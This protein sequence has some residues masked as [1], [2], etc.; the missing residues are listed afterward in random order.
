MFVDPGPDRSD[1]IWVALRADLFAPPDR[2]DWTRRVTD[3]RIL[4]SDRSR[5]YVS[6]GVLLL[7]IAASLAVL[8][9]VLWWAWLLL[10]VGVAQ[11]VL[12]I[13]L[14]PR[15]RGAAMGDSGNDLLA[16]SVR[17]AN[18][19]YERLPFNL[20]GLLGAVAVPVNVLIAIFLTGPDNPGPAKVGLFV[21]TLLYAN[22][23]I[24]GTLMDTPWFSPRSLIDARVHRAQP[25]FWLLV[26]TAAVA[27]VLG[28]AM[29]ERWPDGSLPYALLACGLCYHIG[30]RVRDYCRTM[31]AAARVL[32]Q[33]S[34]E[35]RVS[36]A[37]MLHDTLQPAKYGLP[38]VIESADLSGGQRAALRTMVSDIEELYVE[39]Q[40][41][42]VDSGTLLRASFEQRVRQLVGSAGV[43]YRGSRFDL[44]G[45]LDADNHRF[46][47]H[48][49]TNL[50]QNARDAY[51]SDPFL[52]DHPAIVVTMWLDD[53][54]ASIAVS[55]NLAPIPEIVFA[56]PGS[57]LGSL[58]DR[59]RVQKGDLTQAV[60]SS[61]KTITARWSTALR[62]LRELTSEE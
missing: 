40:R 56:R 47:H 14:E 62:P 4:T 20:T 61:G 13:L 36:L 3:E 22:S 18:R 57:T 34:V 25:F 52:P 10:L 1:N 16:G 33:A 17:F 9:D 42:K 5:P 49:L 59:L 12:E 26:T 21:L 19:M 11:T 44:D 53:G 6:R 30:L 60:D 38:R 15:F 35:E 39:A 48:M 23:G 32:V 37:L 43:S 31:Q 50:V 27:L 8:P 7:G 28:G 54:Y 55:D 41:G 2:S 45:R 46:A 24:L 58:R 29:A 51:E